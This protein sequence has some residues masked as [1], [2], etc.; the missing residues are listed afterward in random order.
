MENAVALIFNAVGQE[1]VAAAGAA[2]YAQ[3]HHLLT[4]QQLINDLAGGAGD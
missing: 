3:I 4:R 2:K 1:R